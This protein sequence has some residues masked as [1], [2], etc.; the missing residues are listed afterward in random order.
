M[1]SEDV[2]AAWRVEV[3]RRVD[4]YLGGNKNLVSVEDSHARIRA[5]LAANGTSNV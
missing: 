2:E 4:D 1:S 5:E 3:T